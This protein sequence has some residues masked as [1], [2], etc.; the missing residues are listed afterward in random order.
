MIEGSNEYLAWRQQRLGKATASR[1]GDII[2]QA[3]NGSFKASRANYAAELV[4]ERLTGVPYESYQNAAMRWGTETQAEAEAA[5]CFYRNTSIEHV[6]GGFINHPQISMS[7][8]SPDALVGRVGLLEIKCPNTATHIA[9]L[10]GA[11]IDTD[12]IAQMQWQMACAG[13]AWCD[14]VS[15]DPRM[16]ENMRLFVQRVA[17]NDELIV[18][19]ANEVSTFLAEVAGTVADLEQRYGAKA[20]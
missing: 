3:R 9:T 16:P 13:R 20:A 1:I 18:R 14:W 15:Y 4:A 2:A 11:E 17:R 12:Y 5:Y 7:G 8:A 19:L 10:R 6:E